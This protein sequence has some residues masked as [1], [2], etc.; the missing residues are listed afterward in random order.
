MKIS[1]SSYGAHD[2]MVIVN[3]SMFEISLDHTYSLY[4]AKSVEDSNKIFR[5]KRLPEF[6]EL[7]NFP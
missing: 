6:K 4:E 2:S 3:Q 5:F 7:K 1:S